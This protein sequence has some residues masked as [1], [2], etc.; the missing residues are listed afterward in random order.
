MPSRIRR[1]LPALSLT[2]C[3]CLVAAVSSCSS[4]PSGTHAQ[5]GTQAQAVSDDTTVINFG[6]Q[7]QEFETLL[8]ASGALAGASYK[9][10][11]VEFDS[12][13]LVDAGFAAHRLDGGEMGDLP[14]ALAVKSGLPVTAI[15]VSLP[16]GASEYLLA[17]PGVTS[18]SQLR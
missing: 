4:S 6:D 11:F 17:R 13:P 16:V 1:L 2:A 15:A 8:N 18:I 14:A 3:A 7:Q 5:G 12:G 10:N 9:V